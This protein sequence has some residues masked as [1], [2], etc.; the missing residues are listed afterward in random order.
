M[1][2]LALIFNGNLAIPNRVKQLDKWL[3]EINIKLVT[4]GSRI[5]ARCSTIVPNTSLFGGPSLKKCLV[6]WIYRVPPRG[7]LILT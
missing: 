6:V 7:L 4:Q 2:L 1:L 5:Y 3:S